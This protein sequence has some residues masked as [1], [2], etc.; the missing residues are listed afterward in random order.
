MKT[1]KN[2]N[3]LSSLT[4][5]IPTRGYNDFLPDCIQSLGHNIKD[6]IIVTPDHKPDKRLD[7]LSKTHHH[8][9]IL[10]GPK[11]RGPALHFGYEHVQTNWVLFLHDD[12]LL[13]PQALIEL[14]NYLSAI[15]K[16]EKKAGY[17]QFQQNSKTVKSYFLAC[18]VKARCFL[19]A[20]PY[21]DQGLLIHRSLYQS[22]GGFNTSY[23]MMEDVDFVSR[24]GR[25]RLHAFCAPLITSDIRYQKGYFKRIMRNAYCLSLYFCGVSP[26][27]IAKIYEKK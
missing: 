24:L 3:V 1:S 7:Q 12:T 5:V 14:E 16:N 17:F 11:G 9:K 13:S 26:H 15:N 10:S 18:L 23:P 21:G 6:I 8:I 22:T 2:K 19:F 27:D 20:L 25:K 4:V